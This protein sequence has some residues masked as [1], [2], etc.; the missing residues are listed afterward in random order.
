MRKPFICFS[1]IFLF[2]RDCLHAGNFCC[3]KGGISIPN[4]RPSGSSNPLNS[5]YTSGLGPDVAIFGEYGFS[6]LFSIEVLL[7]YSAQGGN[8]N[9]KQALPVGNGPTG[10]IYY[11]TNFDANAKMDYLMVPV[12]T[13]FGFNLGI[14]VSVY[15]DAGPFS[16]FC[17]QRKT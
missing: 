16:G 12:I 6:D 15:A 9:G 7:E 2:S 4:L 8:K 11:W 10:P 17:C 3:V 13:K 1:S 14:A 5:G